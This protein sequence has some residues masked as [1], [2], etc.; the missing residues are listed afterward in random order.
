[1][2]LLNMPKVGNRRSRGIALLILNVLYFQE[3]EPLS[4]L[5]KTGWVTG[6]RKRKSL[7]PHKTGVQI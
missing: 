6:K 7:A 4:T 3:S 1:M 2:S 5:N